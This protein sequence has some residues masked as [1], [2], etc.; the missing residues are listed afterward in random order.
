MLGS[1]DG[2]GTGC[3]GSYWRVVP[4]VPLTTLLSWAWIAAVMEI[5]NAVESAGADRVGRLF[6]IS[7]PMWANGLRLVDEQ[8]IAVAELHRRAGAACNLGG[9]ERWGWISVGARLGQRSG[10]GTSRGLR[11]DTV[12]APTRAGRYARRLFPE[13]A[14]MVEQR[15][16]DRFGAEVFDALREQL[17][18]EALTLPWSPPEVHPSDGFITHVTAGEHSPQDLPLVVLLGQR[19]TQRTVEE[20]S[21]IPVSL[22]LAA[23]VL[24]VVEDDQVAVVDLPARTGLSKEAIAMA[25]G[26]LDR[27]HLAAINPDRSISLTAEGLTALE[28]YRDSVFRRGDGDD[29][30]G[31]L[32]DLLHNTEALA[33]GLRPPDRSWRSRKPHLSRT[34]RL[35]ADPTGNLP[36][37]PMVL[38][39]GGWPDG[40]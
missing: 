36:W 12:I 7:F 19:L 25:V 4:T 32:E 8:G 1:V 39:R 30:R 29:V 16:R 9:L 22:P 28:A 13:I 6:K 31:A 14:G 11:A 20:E 3:L 26:N 37:H 2:W 21:S 33:T 34:A 5:D 15:W 27:R 38:H 18:L 17:T 40:S 23:N 24:R 10:Y 35:L